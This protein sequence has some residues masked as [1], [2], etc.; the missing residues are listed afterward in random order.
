MA[1]QATHAA[2][3]NKGRALPWRPRERGAPNAHTTA[4]LAEIVA[5]LPP[6]VSFLLWYS[7]PD[8]S[9]FVGTRTVKALAR[10]AWEGLQSL[11][12]AYDLTVRELLEADNVDMGPDP[13]DIPIGHERTKQCG[14]ARCKAC[15]AETFAGVI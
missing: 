10:R 13:E 7:S 8:E 1:K 2:G 14:T 5:A 12:E 6:G 15:I 11:G 3:P 9:E 4:L